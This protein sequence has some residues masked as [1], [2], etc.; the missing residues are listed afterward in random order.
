MSRSRKKTPVIGN[1]GCRSESY[2]KRLRAG[3]RRTR[4]RAKLA[5]GDYDA[6]EVD[7]PRSGYGPKDGKRWVGRFRDED[8]FEREMGK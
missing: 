1:V 8:W 6:A 4:L 2:Y 3:E 7:L 5:K